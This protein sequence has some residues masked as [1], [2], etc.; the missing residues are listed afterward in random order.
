[1]STVWYTVPFDSVE[2]T[3]TPT[4]NRFRKAAEATVEESC[5]PEVA[6]ADGD[7]LFVPSPA[8]LLSLPETVDL[9]GFAVEDLLHGFPQ[10]E[11]LRAY[12]S[13]P[14]GSKQWTVPYE[15]LW[16]WAD[17]PVKGTCCNVC[18]SWSKL[19]VRESTGKIADGTFLDRALLFPVLFNLTATNVE[20]AVG[21]PDDPV[22]FRTD[23][24]ELFLMGMKPTRM[25]EQEKALPPFL[26]EGAL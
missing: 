7:R 21:S 14:R 15:A 6:Y 10:S 9:E 8:L 1:M 3:P 26:F 11:K 18:G 12:V 24:W 13:R 22:R 2:P 20:I 23:Q 4:A 16:Q 19:Q 17:F 25:T 5:Y